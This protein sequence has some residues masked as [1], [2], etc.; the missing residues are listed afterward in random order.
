[1]KLVCSVSPTLFAFLLFDSHPQGRVPNYSHCLVTQDDVES[2]ALDFT[3]CH[4]YLD[5]VQN[6]ALIDDGESVAVTL[7]NRD[8][9]LLLQ[10]KYRLM[11]SIKDQLRYLLKGVY[12]VIPRELLSVFDYQ[13]LELL[14][15]GVPEIDVQ[16]WKRNTVYEGLFQRQ[17]ARHK[18][19]KWFWNLGTSGLYI[20]S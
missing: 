7:S 18:V 10:L 20:S 11:T 2:L 8:E 14:L 13:E 17:G 3:V 9:Y 15:C 1:M 6:V 19:V 12:E 4:K 16:D 5:Y